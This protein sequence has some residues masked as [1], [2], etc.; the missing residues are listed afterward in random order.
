VT[1]GLCAINGCNGV[2]HARGWCKKHYQA[3]HWRLKHGGVP[4]PRLYGQVEGHTAIYT[5]DKPM[6]GSKYIGTVVRRGY[7][8]RRAK[9]RV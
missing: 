8:W 9:E 6:F 1:A 4:D 7:Q 5:P 3:W 2:H